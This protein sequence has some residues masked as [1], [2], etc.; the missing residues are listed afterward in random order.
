MIKLAPKNVEF[1]NYG[2]DNMPND[3]SKE[4]YTGYEMD[5]FD[6]RIETINLEIPGY[7]L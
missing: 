1:V 5:T 4:T 2:A 6:D 7:N 3:V